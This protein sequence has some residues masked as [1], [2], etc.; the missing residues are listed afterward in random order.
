M[1]FNTIQ[2]LY[3]IKRNSKETKTR[4]KYLWPDKKYLLKTYI[5]YHTLNVKTPDTVPM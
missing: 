4:R 1:A 2:H 5:K 3:L